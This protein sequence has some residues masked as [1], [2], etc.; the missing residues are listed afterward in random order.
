MFPFRKRDPH[1]AT[2][3]PIPSSIRFLGVVAALALSMHAGW[4]L[5]ARQATDPIVVTVP[6]V[7]VRPQPRT[8][9]GLSPPAAS[10]DTSTCRGMSPNPS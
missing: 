7:E 8:G 6:I 9:G 5:A 3:P 1:S 2:A 4:L 10:G